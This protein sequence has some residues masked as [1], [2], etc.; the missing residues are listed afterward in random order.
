M[1]AGIV[2]DSVG[3]GRERGIDS[4]RHLGWKRDGCGVGSAVVASWEDGDL[5]SSARGDFA[6]VAR[7]TLGRQEVL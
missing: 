5:G 1:E 2:G 7:L 6:R 3:L 4:V